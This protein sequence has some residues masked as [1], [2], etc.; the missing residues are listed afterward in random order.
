MIEVKRHFNTAGP[1]MPA[2]HYM[3]DPLPRLADAPRLIDQGK[4]FVV[5][6]PRQSGKTTTL[7]ALAESLARQ[8]RY[9]ALYSSCEAAA[10]LE[11]DQRAE[12]V[13][14][15]TLRVDA[16]TRLAPELRPPPGPEGQ[17]LSLFLRAWAAACPRPLV[18]LLDEVDALKPVPLQ[19]LLRQLRDGYRTDRP[20]DFPWSVVLCGMRDIRDYR[21]AAGLPQGTSSP[22]NIKVESFRLDGFSEVEL[23]TLLD[24][25]T[26][27]T[28]QVF[29]PEA[30]AL[31][32]ALSQGQPWLTNALAREVVE[33]LAITGPIAAEHIEVAKERLILARATHLDSL[34]ARLREPRVQAVIEPVLAGDFLLLETYDDSLLYLRDLGLIAPDDPVRVSNPIYREVIVRTLTAQ[35]QASLPV[36]PHRFVTPDGRLDVVKFLNDFKAFWMEHGDILTVGQAYHEVAP[37]LVIMAYF[38]R[39]VNGGGVITREY[40]VG[41]GAI[42][43]LLRWKLPDGS[44]Q[45]V[46]MELKVRTARTGDPLAKGL[47]QIDGYLARLDLMEGILVIF[48]RRAD[49]P[50]IPE[51]TTLETVMSPE[52]RTITLLRA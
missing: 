10:P 46:A 9:A 18:L 45:R 35:T 4:F 11:D 44:L 20:K 41:R 34:A 13:L 19:R 28:G 49:A 36:S 14:I 25:H 30:R 26:A 17:S 43:L 31:V 12:A 42:D 7:L 8:G 47:R 32:F 51:R 27:E 1:C 37:Q 38:Q 24:Q 5:H 3:I 52:G 22:F 16:E 23:N 50:P 39:V 2:W 33:K 48:D 40:G 6:A 29:T 15:E 21:D